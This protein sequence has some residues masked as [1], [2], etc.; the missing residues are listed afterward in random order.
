MEIP[1]YA[2]FYTPSFLYFRIFD[3]TGQ[4]P[5]VEF[6]GLYEYLRENIYIG[7]EGNIHIGFEG[8]YST[9]TSDWICKTEHIATQYVIMHDIGL[10]Y[11]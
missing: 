2:Y 3:T 1:F 9:L 6:G 4:M 5:E 10:Q 11:F 8:K 7:S